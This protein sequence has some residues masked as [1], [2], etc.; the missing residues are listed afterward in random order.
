MT[1]IHENNLNQLQKEN[2]NLKDEIKQ[3]NESLVGEKRKRILTED[4]L[5]KSKKKPK[6]V[7]NKFK[8]VKYK[9]DDKSF[10]DLKIDEIF[11]NIKSI[12][13]IIKLEKDWNNIKHI[14]KLQKLSNIIIPLKKLDSMVGLNEL[15]AELFKI[16]IYYVQN[17]HVDEYLHTIINGPPGVGKTEF[18]KIYADIFVRLGILSSGTFL[19]IKKNDLV[20]KYLGQTSH[21]TKEL[22]DKAMGGVIF[23]D[24]AYSLG[25]EEKRDSFAKEAIDMINQYLSERKNEFMFIIA[26]YEDD[27]E[28][29]F[30]AFNQGLKR[31]FSHTFTINS[32]TDSEL[33]EIFK[34]KIQKIG[35][36][37]SETMDPK[38]NNFFK[39][40]Y[41][42]FANFAGDIE[43]F[44]NYVKYETTFRSF[45]NRID[46]KQI[47]MED[48]KLAMAKFPKNKEPNPPPPGMYI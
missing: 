45:N 30:F 29:C 2:N 38:I 3:L 42:M 15:K 5:E 13:D 21:R 44:V 19:E 12:N 43:K 28:K 18:A 10:D 24:E 17:N 11:A 22:F 34:Q 37:I 6:T 39:E 35:Y 48:L 14:E 8:F 33:A 4:E 9:K 32:Y 23:L 1:S 16:I 47:T 41:K 31:R 27:L 46:T 26:G 25:N 36:I 20:A 7:S 40:N